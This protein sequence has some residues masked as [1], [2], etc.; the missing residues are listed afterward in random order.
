MKQPGYLAED[1]VVVPNGT[2]PTDGFGK[3]LETIKKTQLLII[4]SGKKQSGKNT[5]SNFITGE[6]LK[7]TNQIRDFKIT[8]TGLLEY[9]EKDKTVVLSEGA[10]NK[11]DFNGV[12]LYSFADPI[13]EFCMN[14]LGLSE[15]QCYGTSEDK[16]TFTSCT[17]G[18]NCKNMTAREVLQIFGTDMVR[19]IYPDA[20]SFATYNLIKD[21]GQELAIITDGRFPNEIDIGKKYGGKSI[22][23]LRNICG[24]DL[25]PSEIAL[26]D[27]DNFDAVLDNRW[28]DIKQQNDMAFPIINEWFREIM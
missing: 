7:R 5:L 28:V 1:T 23:L 14:V 25:H 4:L 18:K 6:Y 8:P 24:I 26:D 10:F 9:I 2:A 15:K 16:D 11:Q 13:K 27:Y 12:K 20:W 21:E 22:R 3:P 19:S 17:W